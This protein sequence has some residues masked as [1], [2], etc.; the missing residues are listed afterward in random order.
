[1]MKRIYNALLAVMAFATVGCIEDINTDMP[2]AESGDEVQF[3]LSLPS[4]ET[5]TLYGIE[6]GNKFPIYWVNGDKVK[7]YAPNCLAGRNNEEYA[8][9][10]PT[11]SNQNFAEKLTPTGA[12]GVQWGA[13]ETATFYSIY[14]SNNVTFAGTEGNATATLNIPSTQSLTHTLTS[15]EKDGQTYGV[16]Y[17]ADMNSVV[18]YA[19]TT[20]SKGTTVN[21]KYIPYSTVIEFDLSLDVSKITANQNPSIIV[22]SMTLTAAKEIKIAGTF[23]FKF[24]DQTISQPQSSNNSSSITLQFA[25]QPELN[26]T[27]KTLRAKMCLMPISGVTSLNG[28]TISVTYRE[29]VTANGNTTVETKTKTLTLNRTDD[30]STALT[31]GKVHKI[32]L[33]LLNATGEW[34]YTP[35]NWMPQIPEYQKVYLT[36]L[37]IPGAWYAGS[38]TGKGYQA[39]ADF[40]ALWTGGVRAYGV[41]CRSYTPRS[42]ILGGGDL[43]NTSP[44]RV[45]L[46]GNGSNQNGAY[47]H[48]WAQEYRMVFVSDIISDI[49]NEVANSNEFAVL[50]LNYADGGSGGHRALDYNYFLA[51]IAKEITESGVTNVVF[52]TEID[53]NT[54][55]KDVLK[56]LI[57][58]VNVDDNTRNGALTSGT[59]ALVAYNPHYIQIANN[60]AIINKNGPFYSKLAW[61]SW[62]TSNAVLQTEPSTSNFL[63]CFSSANRTH[64]DGEGEYEI[65]TYQERKDALEEMIAHSGEIY[66]ASSHNIWFYFNVGGTQTTGLSDETDDING[67]NAKNFASA[68]N[69]WLLQ[70]INRKINGY[71][72][73]ETEVIYASD[74]SPLGI[75]MFNQCTAAAYNGPDIVK[76]IIEMNN[77]FP[78]KKKE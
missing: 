66:E 6:D 15:E 41:E 57:I 69:P 49:A 3:G 33:P 51:G 74:P 50:V 29:P 2:S 60:S 37:S 4:P 14:P 1:M 70:T 30:K 52:G 24:S 20:A 16:Y 65:P 71:T 10:V 55:I 21:L 42:G 58:I 47:T 28:W 56:K 46:S 40:S 63:W 64:E 78:L 35:G 32:T 43:T 27:N 18:M 5:K 39:T 8:V 68:M 61:G 38:E 59:K 62:S 73:P 26:K 48:Q 53:A 22:E 11:G 67:S 9:T 54:T 25:T 76:A 17:A 36:E 44:T 77:K 13:L 19:Q 45:C 23:D 7:V 75:V 31:A 72:D 12:N 34:V